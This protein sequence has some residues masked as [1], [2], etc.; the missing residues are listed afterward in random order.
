[1]DDQRF[2]PEEVHVKAGVPFML[3]VRNQGIEE[4]EFEIPEL[5]IEQEIPA[6]K[7]KRFKIPALRSGAYTL[8]NDNKVSGAKG[9]LIAE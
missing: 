2:T 5:K 6:G 8:I 7:T 4:G 9:R 1:M 3:V